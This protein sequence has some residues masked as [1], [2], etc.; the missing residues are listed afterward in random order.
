MPLSL[1]VTGS[2]KDNLAISL[3]AILLSD[4]NIDVTA[5]NLNT[6]LSSANVKVADYFAPLFA[7][8]IEKSGGIDKFLAG[9]SAGGGGGGAPAAAGKFEYII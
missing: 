1:E 2:Q 8:F 4:S 6:V 7:G 5:D 3:A 9:P